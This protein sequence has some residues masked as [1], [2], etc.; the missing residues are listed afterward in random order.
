M[1]ITVGPGLYAR[2]EF[3]MRIEDVICVTENGYENF[4]KSSKDLVLL[5]F[6]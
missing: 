6:H 3:G 5:E 4:N 2:G 1:V